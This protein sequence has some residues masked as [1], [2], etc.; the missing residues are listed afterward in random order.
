[1]AHNQAGTGF[2]FRTLPKQDTAV[3]SLCS[4]AVAVFLGIPILKVVRRWTEVQPSS[5][6]GN[7][8]MAAYRMQVLGAQGY[9]LP[10][11]P[12]IRGGTRGCGFEEPVGVHARTGWVQFT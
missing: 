12:G 3:L 10:V 2:L 8:T 9:A 5:G 7:R 4:T 1:M 11:K 6:A